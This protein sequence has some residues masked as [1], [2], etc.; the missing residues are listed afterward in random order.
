MAEKIICPKCNGTSYTASPYESSRCP[1]CGFIFC[2]AA[3]EEGKPSHQSGRCGGKL[4]GRILVIDDLPAIRDLVVD[5]LTNQGYEVEIATNGME[6]L[7]MTEEKAYDLIIS[8]LNMPVMG[9]IEFYTRLLE[10]KPFMK[11][12]VLFITGNKDRE[13]D[14]FL[15]ETGARYLIKPFKTVDLLKAVNEPC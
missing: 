8:D 10:E 15:K 5:I 3:Q 6:G 14:I 4:K 1:Y 7:K 11:Q 2:K 9:G 13:T 12:R